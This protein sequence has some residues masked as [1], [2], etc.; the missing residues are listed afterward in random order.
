MQKIT[1]NEQKRHL[2]GVYAVRYH[3][4]RILMIDDMTREDMDKA[5]QLKRGQA[6]RIIYYFSHIQNL[7][8]SSYFSFTTYP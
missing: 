6:D 2:H 7:P 4:C 8:F 5:R 1:K 3:L